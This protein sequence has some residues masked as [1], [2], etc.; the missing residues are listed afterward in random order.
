MEYTNVSNGRVFITSS[1]SVR[2]EADLRIGT[3]KESCILCHPHPLYGGDM[4]NLV[5][6]GLERLFRD[7]GF[8]TLR[9]NFR[10]VGCSTGKYSDG[11]GEVEDVLAC[12]RYL[13]D[14]GMRVVWGVGYS[15]GAWVLN[16]AIEKQ[17]RWAGLVLVSPPVDFLHFEDLTS[18]DIPMFIVY[19]GN[20][21]FCT[22]ESIERWL[23]KW[24]CDMVE[25]RVLDGADHF[26]MGRTKELCGAVAI[27]IDG[28][29]KNTEIET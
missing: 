8:T 26:Y 19:G 29:S 5:V 24:P 18:L 23:R 10:G 13:I 7:R 27:F 20:D 4:D 22:K 14:I 3:R 28:K 17:P 6:V 2:I 9:F 21:S 11:L 25:Q 16:R 1:D 12:Y 15:F